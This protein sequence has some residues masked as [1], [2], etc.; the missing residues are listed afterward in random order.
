MPLVTF[1]KILP[2]ARAEGR[3]VCAFNIVNCETAKA[4][5]SAAEQTGRPVILQMYRRLFESDRARYVAALVRDM[6]A[7]TDAL[8]ALHLDHGATLDQVRMAADYGFSA[9]MFDGSTLPLEENIRQTRLAAEIAHRAGISLEGEIGHVPYNQDDA[10]PFPT[11]EEVVRFARET[12]V[13]ALAVAV[14]TT[15][16]FYKKTPQIRLDLA[17]AVSEAVKIPLVLHGGSD[18][19][20]DKVKALVAC[21]FA[22]INIATEFFA[23]FL[24][25]VRR[26]SDA[27]AGGFKPLDLFLAPVVDAMTNLAVTKIRMVS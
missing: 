26:Q 23:A 12:G 3:S 22:K 13:D 18:T 9:A 17:R 1:D 6:A 25:E 4:A 24:A 27:L 20:E 11:P 7:H 5:I 14:G 8:V 15:H 10:I 2:Q 21:G 16:G 19:P